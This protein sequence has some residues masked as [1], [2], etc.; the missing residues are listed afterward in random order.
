M[1][2][3]VS[4]LHRRANQATLFHS[5]PEPVMKYV[6]PALSVLLAV[7]FLTGCPQSKTPDTPPLVPQPKAALGLVSL[8]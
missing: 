3:R 2:H 5:Q 7:V 8:S 4:L 1:H 6:A